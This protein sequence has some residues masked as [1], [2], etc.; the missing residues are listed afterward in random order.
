MRQGHL[1]F[2]PEY[3]FKLLLSPPERPRH[4]QGRGSKRKPRLQ[5]KKRCFESVSVCC[6][7]LRS[8][9]STCVSVPLCRYTRLQCRPAGCRCFLGCGVFAIC[10]QLSCTNVGMADGAIKSQGVLSTELS[11]SMI[12]WL[13]VIDGARPTG[14]PPKS[15]Q[16]AGKDE[17]AVGM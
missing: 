4:T 13:F 16:T 7:C 12:G 5:Y 15:I 17:M 6:G 14:Q 1:H 9:V 11:V 10:S 8:S 3:F 2:L